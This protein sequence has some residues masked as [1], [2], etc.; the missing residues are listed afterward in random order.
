MARQRLELSCAAMAKI[1]WDLRRSAAERLGVQ[2]TRGDR[3]RNGVAKRGPEMET[4]RNESTDGIGDAA[5]RRRIEL[6]GEKTL[7]HG[8][9]RNRSH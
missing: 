9:D 6:L 3:R 2:R 4:I 7:R 5:T 8:N 1:G